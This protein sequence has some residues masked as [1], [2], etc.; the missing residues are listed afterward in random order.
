MASSVSRRAPAAAFRLL[1]WVASGFAASAVLIGGTGHVGNAVANG[2]TRTIEIYHTHTRESAT[3]TYKRDGQ[4]DA[5]ALEKLNWILRDWRRDEPIRMDPRLFD[6]VWE[7]RREVGSE[8]PLHVVSAY[9]APETNAMLRRRS[10][11]VAEHS[12][13]MA[14]KAMDFFLPDVSMAKVR[15][16]A[17]RLQ[18]GGVGYYPTS[19]N[20]FV[21]LDA[22]SVRH[23]PRM[24]RDQLARVFPDGK[25]VHI[26]TDGK[27][28]PRYEEALAEIQANGGVAYADAGDSGGF[29]SNRR[30]KSFFAALF[31][32]G[33]GDED[34]VEDVA[35][36]GRA[37]PGGRTQ[38]ASVA[39]AQLAYAPTAFNGE[40]DRPAPYF[41]NTTIA[42]SRPAERPAPAPVRAAAPTPPEPQPVVV[43]RAEPTPQ[44][45]WSQGA[46]G[47]QRTAAAQPQ[48]A[49]VPL[50]TARPSGLLPPVAL[51]AVD[52]P[53][54]PARPVLLAS[55][56]PLTPGLLPASPETTSSIGPA[57]AY[58]AVPLPPARPGS[59]AGVKIAA[60]PPPTALPRQEALDRNGLAWL[61]ARARTETTPAADA[62]VAMAKARPAAPA[63]DL[64]P[65][66]AKPHQAVAMRFEARP[67]ADLAT[68]RFAGPAVK[69]LPVAR[70]TP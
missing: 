41:P 62:H 5:A 55:A 30:G 10:R 59:L 43:A 11:A 12:Q 34:E 21:H 24:T 48:F 57:L 17:L 46:A 19:Y 32:R 4:F 27:P 65:M 23:W 7:V 35:P 47:Q 39:P 1:R 38:V 50:P 2:E 42:P 31:G 53:L 20:P 37:R 44:F 51:A 8:E 18:R 45:V 26:P 56:G 66:T 61:F 63:R 49:D 9:R 54:P 22:G 60:A 67:A 64:S 25:T 52:V 58:A 69:A 70:F 40:S 15:E 16:I 3:I 13:H 6:I 28:M 14:G 29:F 68:D 36:R 33:G